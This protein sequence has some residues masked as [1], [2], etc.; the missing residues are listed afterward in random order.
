MRF[1]DSSAVV[2]LLISQ[3]ATARVQPLI[4]E[5]P[6]V[7]LWWGTAVECASALAR[8]RRE[9]V[10]SLEEEAEVHALLDDWLETCVEVQSSQRL[11]RSALRLL[12]IHPLRA[13]DALQLAAALEWA[14]MPDGHVLVTLDER[15]GQAARLEGFHVVPAHR[16]TT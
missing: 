14:G 13:A 4:D 10:L 6:D 3:P 9:G 16:G 12:R 15:L 5:V 8:L 1:W 11:R 2:P 7:V